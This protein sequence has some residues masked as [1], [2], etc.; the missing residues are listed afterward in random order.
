MAKLIVDSR[1][2]TSGM[3]ELLTARGAQVVVEELACADYILAEDMAVERK[4]A[5]DFVSA[6]IKFDGL[7]F[8]FDE[9]R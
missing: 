7:I 1:E 9:G 8:N 4:T 5:E 3:I 6:A 2:T